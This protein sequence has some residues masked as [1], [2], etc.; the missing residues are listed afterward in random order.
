MNRI[1]IWYVSPL[2]RCN[3]K[4]AYCVSHQPKITDS[5]EWHRPED[6]A[7]HLRVIDWI[8]RLPQ[9][10]RLRMGSTGEP[11]VSTSYLSSIARLTQAENLD[12]VEV[13]TN[14][15]WSSKQF[16]KFLGQCDPAKLTLWMTYHHSEMELQRFVDAAIQARDLGATVIVHA[17]LF[18]DN[19]R[20]SNAL[21]DLCT[22]NALPLHVGLGLNVN[23]AYPDGSFVPVLDQ[24]DADP[25]LLALNVA[26]APEVYRIAENPRGA[27]CSAGHDYIYID[28]RGE[29][30]QCNTYAKHYPELRLGSAVDPNF[31]LPLRES[32][33]AACG[34]P[35][36]CICVEDYQHLEIAHERQK[37][38]RPSL[39]ASSREEIF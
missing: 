11:F 27:P 37:I 17:L 15:S 39:I 23:K 20:I 12:F 1:S 35:E 30:H 9:R 22:Q 7:Q 10:V 21:K 38:V 34:T 19:L 33:F 3:F 6:E 31:V 28:R 18:P 13:L 25:A 16:E 24:P 26:F 29:V 32:R 5:L 8:C 36:R 2:R 4:C 14:G